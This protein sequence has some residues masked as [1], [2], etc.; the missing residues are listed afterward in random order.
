MSGKVDGCVQY[1]CTFLSHK[2]NLDVVVTLLR[3]IIGKVEITSLK[4]FPVY[5]R[6]SKTNK[7]EGVVTS[8]FKNHGQISIPVHCI[9]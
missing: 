9:Y 5:N 1:P 8:I 6:L 4:T 7:T 2:Y 3:G